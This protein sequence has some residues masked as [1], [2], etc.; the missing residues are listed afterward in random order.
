LEMSKVTR[1]TARCKPGIL[2]PKMRTGKQRRALTNNGNDRHELSK[3][4]FGED[5]QL[6][7]STPFLPSTASDLVE[8]HSRRIW[9]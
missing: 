5:F 1:S 8:S 4:E 3:F 2:S 7:D 9:G 6:G